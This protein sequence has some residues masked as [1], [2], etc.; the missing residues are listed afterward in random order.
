MNNNDE[1]NLGDYWR[2]I[3][4]RKWV[5]IL[6]VVVVAASAAIYSFLQ[7]PIYVT[8]TTLYL[9]K[10]EAGPEQIDVFSGA[11]VFSTEMEINSQIEI[12]RSRTMMEEVARRLYPVG[13]YKRESGKK[14]E[15]Y[16]YLRNLL[17][18]ILGE[19]SEEEKPKSLSEI[20]TSLRGSISM[21]LIPNT[22]LI[23][24]T[25]SSHDPEIAW[26][27]ANTI[28][29]V[30]IERDISFRQIEINA[31]LDFF[32]RETKKVTEDLWQSEKNLREYKEKEGFTQLS[33]KARLIVESLS[34]LETLHGS[35]RIFRE[36]LNNR[37]REIRSQL[38]EVSKVW[39]S[40]TYISDDPPVQML[41]SRLTNLEI[42][43]AQLS[44]EFSSH[45]PQVT[46]VESQIEEIKR[47]LKREVKTVVAG[48][49]EGISSIYTGPYTKLVNYE[50]EINALKAK[51][52]ALGS[53]VA[54]YRAEMNKL[55]QQELTLARLERD[56]QVNAEL[57]AVLVK[58]KDKV[59]IESASELGII[60]VVDPAL[61]PTSPV[62]PKK[63]QNTLIGSV[64]GLMLGV[65]F[66]FLLESSDKTIKTEDE[67]KKLLNL[68]VLGIIPQPGIQSSYSYGYFYG[69]G[70][71]KKRKEIKTAISLEKKMPIELITNQM[72]LSSISEAYI[73]LRTNFRFVDL[74]LD[75]KLKTI[76]ITSSIPQEGKTSVTTNLGIVLAEAGEKVLL[77]DADLRVPNLHKI[78][79]FEETPG[80]TDVLATDKNYKDIIHS[81]DKVDNLYVLTCGPP[82]PNPSE[83]LM[84]EKM[85]KLID[86]LREEY[87]RILF[88]LPPVL[89]ISDTSILSSNV[90]GILFV[91]GANEV[92]RKAVQKAKE[93]LEKVK[94]HILGLVLN[95]VKFEHHG[96]GSYHYY[97]S[98]K[99]NK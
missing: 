44:M 34:K 89:G 92:D 72:P 95:K 33:E 83:L 49:T 75:K 31:A 59:E 76:L 25:A 2:V 20:A 12:L 87:D 24:L 54:E 21:S 17:T 73:S 40:S 5:V 61:K 58:L 79:L 55:P 70:K 27:T 6:T 28:A 56:Q 42:K 32:S 99:D 90:D 51:E 69:G 82:A 77:V 86:K 68:P 96:Y 37:L 16:E 88:D 48:N 43:H 45:D 64:L 65:F 35:T 7:T 26:S 62:K 50:A 9:K 36:E 84:S 39:V 13:N 53:L 71:R 11:S 4:R 38:E 60:Q 85:K 80:L 29:E 3:W 15:L 97:R 91:L 66:V 93:S 22:R 8:S 81:V 18:P 67:A 63:K 74:D 41:R 14:S 19:S 47:E 10:A 52:N 94:A 57:Y 46:Y 30:F 78:F 1:L 23:T 98:K